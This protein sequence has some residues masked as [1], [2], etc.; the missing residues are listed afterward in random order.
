MLDTQISIFKDMKSPQSP[1]NISVVK[2]LDRIKNGSAATAMVQ[3]FRTTGESKFKEQLPAVCFSGTFSY[4][5]KDSLIE[6]SQL[7][8]L[9]FDKFNGLE[10][11]QQMKDNLC[12]DECLFCCFISPS[13]KGVKAVFRVA[14][15]PTKYEA[16]YR[17]LCKK[18]PDVHLDSKTKDI[19]RLCFE[20]YD[21]EIFIN[22]NAKEWTE[23][24]EDEYQNLGV[25]KYEVNV[26]LKS[27]S[28]I[29]DLLQTWFD[30]KYSFGSGSRNDSI[31][32]FAGALNAYGINA[33]SYTHLTLPTI[34]SV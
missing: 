34:Y 25:N 23:C 33:V 29:I 31:H 1:Y 22:E 2:F 24:E 17:A 9:D 3:Q 15:D 7:A 14:N 16:M 10:D 19:S 6:F 4:R 12:Q 11:A 5:R 20:S 27:E 21:P 26:P 18:Y 30:R 8:C 32:S 28:R 13:G